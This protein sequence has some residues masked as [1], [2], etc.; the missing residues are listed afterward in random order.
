[1]GFGK[2]LKKAFKQVTNVVTK[3][4]AQVAQVAGA[5]V[6]LL[7]GQQAGTSVNDFGAPVMTQ[8]AAVEAP[9]DTNAQVVDD[10]DTEAGRR[11]A[12]AGGK[13]SLSVTRASGSGLNL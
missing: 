9:L 12:R 2:A 11:K 13:R 1:M 8:A 5:G 10:A 7:T 4:V 6:G 3:P